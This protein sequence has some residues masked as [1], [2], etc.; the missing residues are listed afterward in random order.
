MYCSSHNLPASIVVTLV[1][2]SLLLQASTGGFAEWAEEF[3]TWKHLLKNE[4]GRFFWNECPGH[5]LPHLPNP[6]GPG[7]LPFQFVLPRMTNCT[8]PTIFWPL[9]A[10]NECNWLKI[11]SISVASWN[12]ISAL[13]SQDGS[14]HACRPRITA[15]IANSIHIF[16]FISCFH[17]SLSL[18]WWGGV[19]AHIT[20][21]IIIISMDYFHHDQFANCLS[22]GQALLPVH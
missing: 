3:H 18:A 22:P 11:Q 9:L 1:S 15:P 6:P 4:W 12:S 19:V 8:V 2:F 13:Q 21:M 5:C 16:L 17:S 20:K 10:Q 7:H 14:Y